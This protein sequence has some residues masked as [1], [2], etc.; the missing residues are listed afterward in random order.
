MAEY[1]GD[2]IISIKADI[3]DAQAYLTTLGLKR[4]AINKAL[5]RATGTGGKRAV[6][7]NYRTLLKRRT[8]NMYKG[9]KSIVWNNGSR[10]VFTDEVDSGKN[11]AKD[12]RIARYAFMLASGYTNTPKQKNKPMRFLAADGKWV[13]TYGYK[14]EAKDWMDEPLGRYVNSLDL[15]MRLDKALQSQVDKWEKKHGGQTA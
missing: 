13:S 12:G 6:K 8:G 1:L 2:G 4:K 10:V 7:A 15:K 14:V 5:L 3:A 9:I 11:T